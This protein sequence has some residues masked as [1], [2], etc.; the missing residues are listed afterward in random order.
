MNIYIHIYTSEPG[1][2]TYVS[3][4]DQDAG[5]QR[6]RDEA[7]G[8][9]FNARFPRLS[10]CRQRAFFMLHCCTISFFFFFFNPNSFYDTRSLQ[11]DPVVVLII[12]VCSLTVSHLTFMDNKSMF[13]VLFSLQI[14]YNYI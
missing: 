9:F 8:F 12:T 13:P 2:E 3:P 4:G 7:H 10:H 11:K 14:Q 1:Y 6:W 5:R